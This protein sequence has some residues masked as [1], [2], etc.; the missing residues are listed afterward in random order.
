MFVVYSDMWE[1]LRIACEYGR[2]SIVEHLLNTAR[3]EPE[4][5]KRILAKKNVIIEQFMLVD[6]FS[7]MVNSF[8]V[9]LF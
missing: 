9:N 4:T 2:A 6:N 3:L 1:L 8:S 7:F 5:E